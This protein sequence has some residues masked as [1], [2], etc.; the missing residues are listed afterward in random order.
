MQQMRAT[1]FPKPP[2]GVQGEEREM[3]RLRANWSICADVQKA[4]K[5]QHE[6][7]SRNGEQSRYA[8]D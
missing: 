7:K 3:Q 2:S 5:W 8:A 1:I 6:K 4:K